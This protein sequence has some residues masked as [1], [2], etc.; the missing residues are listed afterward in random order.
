MDPTLLDIFLENA[1][2]PFYGLVVALALW[3]Y[4]RYYD[5]PLRYFPVLLMYTFLNEL[6]GTITRN[7]DSVILL[8]KDI[9]QTN[10]WVIF[11]IYN[12][13]FFLYFFYV[14][15]QY[16]SDMRRKKW[17][18]WGGFFFLTITVINVF[19]QSFFSLPQ[20]YAYSAGSAVLLCCIL[21]YYEHLRKTEGVYFIK[22]D[23]LS[24][25]GAG[26]L[27]FYSGY[28]P[29]KLIRYYYA[30]QDIDENPVVR[31]IHLFL[32]LIMYLFF[33]IGFIRMRRRHG[34]G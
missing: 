2:I 26:M 25:V 31:R 11:N 16:I 8:L 9:Y 7:N 3:R 18:L 29:I 1:F 32:I 14:Y 17:I 20:L 30:S 4:P 28:V 10:N 34:H 12:I 19:F 5:T 23:L 13:I 27:I 15:R 24:W 6:L 33:A 21:L 22:R